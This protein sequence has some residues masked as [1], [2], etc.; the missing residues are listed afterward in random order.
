MSRDGDDCVPTINV[1]VYYSDEDQS[2]DD[3]E[4][5]RHLYLDYFTADNCQRG[6]VEEYRIP[7]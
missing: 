6:H 4:E 5:E 2:N 3:E 7:W 1:I